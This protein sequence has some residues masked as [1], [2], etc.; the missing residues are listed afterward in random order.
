MG[1]G[2]RFTNSGA[3]TRDKESSEIFLSFGLIPCPFN[4]IHFNKELVVVTHYT[5]IV[6]VVFLS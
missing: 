4:N 6:I 3:V 1:L 2:R 5:H